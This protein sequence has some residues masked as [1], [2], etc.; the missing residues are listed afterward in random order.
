[1]IRE[2]GR[3]DLG[4]TSGRKETRRLGGGMRKCRRIKKKWDTERTEDRRQEDRE[5]QRQEK[6]Q[7]EETRQRMHDEVRRTLKRMKSERQLVLMRHHW[8]TGGV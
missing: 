2:T 4:V 3:R 5:M 1:M 7:V 6:I 8:R